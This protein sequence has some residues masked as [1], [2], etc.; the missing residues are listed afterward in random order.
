MTD[1]IGIH[2][3]PTLKLGVR[4]EDKTRA[5]LAFGDFLGV[6]PAHPLVDPQPNLN[7]PID[8]NNQAGT[9]VVAASDHALQ[10]IYTLLAGSYTNWSD[11][12]I[13]RAYQTQNPGFLSWADSNGPNDGGM[14][15]SLFLSWLISQK[16]IL[17][18]AKVD[19]TNAAEVEAAIYLGLAVLTAENL[20]VAQQS[21]L[22]WDYVPGSPDW[23]GHATDWG[24]YTPNDQVVTWGSGAYSMTP[25]FVANQVSDAYF[26]LTQAHVDHP[27]FRDHFDLAGFAAAYTQITGQ[28][29]PVAVPTPPKP[30]VPPAP[31]PPVTP[32]WPYVGKPDY[33]GLV[34]GPAA[35]HSGDPRYD[36]AA[37]RANIALIQKAL[38]A[39]GY[40]GKVATSWADGIYGPPT[41]AAVKRFQ[42]AHRLPVNGC[43]RSAD[44]LVLLAGA[45]APKTSF[46]RRIVTTVK[47]WLA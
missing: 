30:P 24:G 19:V 13:L 12:F 21:G 11:A 2:T 27:S 23:G 28:P 20:T 34:T 4:P 29:F 44:W 10:I 9:C 45:K 14:D 1:A 31:R 43:V 33:F 18:Y 46:W 47:G 41:F 26:I 8:R 36:T 22:V 7:Y 35:C 17:G 6:A 32:A 15:P 37:C 25:A 38:I 16:L 42:A 5:K 3:H 40:A 39:Q